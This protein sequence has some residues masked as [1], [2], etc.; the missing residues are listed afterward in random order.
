MFRESEGAHQRLLEFLADHPGE[1]LGS[2]AIADGLGLKHGRKSLAGSLGAFGRRAD[3]RYG[4]LKPFESHWDGESYQAKLRMSP[5]VAAWVK[6]A[7]TS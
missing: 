1:W 2:Q 4:G 3:H 6:A 5:K 7:A